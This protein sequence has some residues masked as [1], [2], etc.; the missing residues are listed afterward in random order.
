MFKID[1]IADDMTDS[2]TTNTVHSPE[3]QAEAGHGGW[4]SEQG[5]HDAL[6]LRPILEMKKV[7]KWIDF[8]KKQLSS[9]LNYKGLQSYRTLVPICIFRLL[10]GIVTF[11]GNIF[12]RSKHF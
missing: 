2:T 3:I 9:V 4:L 10:V 6:K 1:A 11:L 7:H 5:E 8:V 12:L